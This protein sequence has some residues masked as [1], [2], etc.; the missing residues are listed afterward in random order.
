[1]AKKPSALES[2]F[3]GKSLLGGSLNR[4]TV[5]ELDLGEIIPNPNN[6]RSDFDEEKLQ[7]LADSIDAVGLLSP[8][9]VQPT[10]NG[11]YQLVAG[12][13]RYRAH[14]VLG[15]NTIFAIATEGQPDEI[16]LIENVQRED[17]NPFEL[18]GGLEKLIA[19][20]NYSQGAVAKI[21]GRSQPVVSGLLRINSLPNRIKED[22]PNAPH[23][24]ASTLL[25][26]ARADSEKEQLRLWEEAKN[27]VTVRDA[28]SSR[29]KGETAPA[30]PAKLAK[31][32]IAAG[33][34]FF[35]W[36]QQAEPDKLIQDQSQYDELR[37]MR[38]KLD[39]VLTRYKRER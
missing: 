21:I 11:K 4:P 38:D 8:I 31:Q 28:R 35:D 26:I 20:H 9:T 29:R 22:Y 23:L 37:A 36:L 34:R 24:T 30:E 27:G 1:M 13:R 3:A 12:E 32:H 25:E 18:A 39:Q 6:P 7:T 5:L 16:A 15:K 14:K 10:D 2:R 17:L 33:R 19:N